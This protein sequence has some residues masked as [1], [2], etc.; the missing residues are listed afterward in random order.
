MNSCCY[1]LLR[2]LPD[3]PEDVESVFLFI[4]DNISRTYIEVAFAI[5]L[6]YVEHNKMVNTLREK[7]CRR[8]ENVQSSDISRI[9]RRSLDS[10]WG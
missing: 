10:F 5:L 9:F 1:L 2:V 8:H 4:L 6:Y 7:L 3:E